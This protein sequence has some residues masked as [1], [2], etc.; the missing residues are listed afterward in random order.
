MNRIDLVDGLTGDFST[1]FWR[2]ING[3]EQ[4]HAMLI[5][6]TEHYSLADEH[7]FEA[8]YCGMSI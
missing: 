8:A 4:R 7:D 2:N 6:P 5:P 3:A 1:L